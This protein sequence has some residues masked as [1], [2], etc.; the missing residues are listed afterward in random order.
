MPGMVQSL[1]A[2]ADLAQPTSILTPK[3]QAQK[4][5]YAKIAYQSTIAALESEYEREDGFDMEPVRSSLPSNLNGI[6][7]TPDFDDDSHADFSDSH[8]HSPMDINIPDNGTTAS[9]SNLKNAFKPYKGGLDL[10]ELPDADKWK[11]FDEEQDH[12][13]PI[14]CEEM[15]KELNEM[16]DADQESSLWDVC[17]YI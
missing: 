1:P 9:L 16:M 8:A 15:Q 10:E 6:T 3:K 11:F 7:P 13:M 14:S 17:T 12:D 5:H 2:A 4:L